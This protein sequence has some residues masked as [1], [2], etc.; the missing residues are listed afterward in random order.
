MSVLTQSLLNEKNNE[1]DELTAEVER[2]SAEIE[3][4]RAA[5]TQQLRGSSL[6]VEVH[7]CFMVFNA[8]WLVVWVRFLWFYSMVTSKCLHCDAFQLHM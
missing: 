6:P 3:R 2:L 4:L 1:I 5:K 7:H 8:A